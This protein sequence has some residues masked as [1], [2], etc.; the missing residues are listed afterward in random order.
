LSQKLPEENFIKDA[1]LSLKR[2]RFRKIT[3]LLKENHLI[4]KNLN[5]LENEALF[6]D[7]MKL[8]LRLKEEQSILAKETGTVVVG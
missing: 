3:K 5:P 2:F 7:Y 6:S 1:M 4:L 8:H